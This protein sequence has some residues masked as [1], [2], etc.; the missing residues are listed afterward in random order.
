MFG[1][2]THPSRQSGVKSASVSC[3][4]FKPSQRSAESHTESL[5]ESL[6]AATV[7]TPGS[8]VTYSV[9]PSDALNTKSLIAKSYPAAD[10]AKVKVART[11]V[12]A[13]K[14]APVKKSK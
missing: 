12:P 10:S 4:S 11:P 5:S 1:S 9:I 6:Q 13:G 2:F 3:K 8:F 7:V 14:V